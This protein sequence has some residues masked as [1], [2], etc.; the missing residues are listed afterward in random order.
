MVQVV[1][2]AAGKQIAMPQY[3]KYQPKVYRPRMSAYWWLDQWHYLR[4]ALREASSFFVAYF[5]VLTLVQIAA[6]N[7]GH[8]Q[9][10]A[11]QACL[12][13]PFMIILNA[14][15]LAFVLFHAITWFNLVPRVMVRQITGRPLPDAIASVPNFFIWFGAS[16]IVALFILGI[17]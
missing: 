10:A 16:L 11:F 1:P 15:T 4:Y 13:S 5:A 9:Y 3:A 7:A 2:D 12:R 17:L 14:I 6:L 8:D